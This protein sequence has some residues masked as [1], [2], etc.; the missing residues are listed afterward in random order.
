MFAKSTVLMQRGFLVAFAAAAV[1][2]LVLF[3]GEKHANHGGGTSAEEP[4]AKL[5]VDPPLPGPLTKGVAI[6]K[7]RTE[8]LQIAPVFGPAAVAVSPRLGHLHITVD[9]SPWHWANTSGEP[10]IVAELAKGPHQVL[11]ELADANHEVL[12]REV[13]KFDVP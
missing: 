2:G 11:F 10:V 9:N 6:I 5:V 8:N 12:A 1:S 13:V 7:Y 4:A 3:A